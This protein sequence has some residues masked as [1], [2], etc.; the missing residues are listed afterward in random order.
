MTEQEY[1]QKIKNF[2]SGDRFA[3][4]NGIEITEA[5]QG[6]A[7]CTCSIAPKHLNAGGTVQGGMLFTLG[8]FTFAAAAN[9]GGIATVTLDS[10]ISFHRP[11]KGKKLIAIAQEVTTGRT[12]CHYQVEISDELGTKVASMAVT[13]YQKGENHI[14]S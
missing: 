6:Y 12:I 10:S 8:D 14:F 1:L 4:E 11:A 2:F 7:R 13:G 9:A 5:R 3:I